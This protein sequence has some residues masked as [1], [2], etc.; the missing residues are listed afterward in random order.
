MNKIIDVNY[1]FTEDTPNFWSGYWD[2][3]M[4]RSL[5]DPDAYSKTL[6]Q[7]H[8]LLWSKEL[9][10]KRTLILS[11]SNAKKYLTWEE[12]R[13]GSDS[14]TASFRYKKYRH[15]IR[16]VM[17]AVP[18][19]RSFIEDYVKRSYT[20]GGTIIFPKQPWGINQARG[21]NAYIRD[22]FDLTLECIRLYYNKQPNPL[23][24]VL[25]RNK[26]FFD[27]FVDFK[28][29]V[30][31]F[32]LQDLVEADY[33]SV[34]LFINGQPFEINPFPKTVEEYFSWMNTQMEF[35]KRRNARI[36]KAINTE[37]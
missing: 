3:E 23:E 15:M 10:S 19:Y 33:S 4:G 5:V 18:N 35:V 20:I 29:Y 31:F 13:F 30:D 11:D 24:D 16:K 8:K 37:S 14:I 12:F 2:E 32:Y 9:P 25:M 17:E 28:G 6:K 34:K 22:R 27:L 7:Y 1:S 21:C 26:K 36:D